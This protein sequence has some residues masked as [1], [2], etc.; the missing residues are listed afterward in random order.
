MLAARA[1]WIARRSAALWWGSGPP[2]FTAMTMSLVIRV[3]T[4][5]IRFQRANMV[6]L[7][8]SKMRPMGSSGTRARG[9]FFRGPGTGGYPSGGPRATLGRGRKIPRR[10]ISVTFSGWVW[11]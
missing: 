8:V 11:A 3:K 5:A 4:F 2:D 6:A 10:T 9:A 7:R 1:F